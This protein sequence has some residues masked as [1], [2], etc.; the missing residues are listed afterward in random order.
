MGPTKCEQSLMRV[1]ESY[2]LR[3]TGNS[4]KYPDDA[5]TKRSDDATAA[6]FVVLLNVPWQNSV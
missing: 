5:N 6:L 4:Q 1:R 3:D 2:R